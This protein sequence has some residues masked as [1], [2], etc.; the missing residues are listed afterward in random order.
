MHVRRLSLRTGRREGSGEGV[1]RTTDGKPTLDVQMRGDQQ[2]AERLV[3][4]LRHVERCERWTHGFHTYPAGLHPD[5]ARDLV[6]LFQPAALFDPFCGGGTSLI[7]GMA[8]G[9]RTY[10]SDVSPVAR[11]V[12]TGRTSRCDEARA[13]RLRSAARKLAEAARHAERLPPEPILAVVGDWYAPHVLCEIEAVRAGISHAPDDVQDLLWF[14]LS[15]ILVKASWRKS[16]TSA[17]REVGDRPP[18]TT[19][20]LFHKKVRELARRA[21][22]LREAVPGGTPDPVIRSA[23]ARAGGPREAGIDLILTSPPYPG[24]YDYVP[25]QQLREAWLGVEGGGRD[26]IGARRHWHRDGHVSATRRWQEDT[27]AWTLAAADALVPGGHLVIVV[28]DGLTAGGSVDALGPSTIAAEQAGLRMLACA[29]LARPDHARGA[30]RWEHVVACE[31]PAR[32]AP[33]AERAPRPGSE[34]A[35]SSTPNPFRGST[36]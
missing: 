32:S 14:A 20:T 11:L 10:G 1:M 12:A 7:E 21:E 17:Q 4:A 36:R 18:G 28:G 25:M 8:A 9:A 19:A 13:T 6:G 2:L 24:V 3:E 16:D 23:D 15:S 33:R 26:E 31:R 35:R 22:A 29:S 30:V 34:A 27:E 5:A